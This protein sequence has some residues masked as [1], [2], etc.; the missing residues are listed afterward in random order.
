MKT[1]LKNDRGFALIVA[2]M[3]MVIM[4]SLT[5]AGLLFSGLNLKTTSSHKT[6]TQAFYIADAGLHHV[7]QELDN[8]DGINDFAT[9]YTATETTTLFANTSFGSG[10]YTVTALPIAGSPDRIRVQSTGCL[11]AGCPSGSS[12]AVIEADLIH[13][14]GK[15]PKAVVTNG[16]L[17]I[18]QDPKIMGTRG[19][20]HSNDDMQIKRHPAIEMVN[21]LTASNKA[22][23]EGSIPEGMVIGPSSNPC[24]GSP[25]CSLPSSQQ[26]EENKIN[27]PEKRQAYAASHSSAPQVTIPRINPADY[28]PKV[29]ALAGL[30]PAYIMHDDGTVTTGGS[31]GLDGLCV[32]GTPVPVPTGWRFNEGAWRPGEYAAN[33]IYYSETNIHISTSPGTKE[34][35]WEVTLIA[36]DT[37]MFTN[38]PDMKPY[39]TT[40]NELKNHLL[41][42]GNDLYLHG[43]PRMDYVPGAILVHQQFRISD[44]AKIKGFIIAGDGQPTWPGDPFPP[45]VSSSGIQTNEISGDPWIT[46]NGDFDCLG[47]GCPNP[48]KMLSWREVF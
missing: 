40:S 11:P 24:I 28:A 39:P 3:V 8:S 47:P 15:A 30:E 19:G 46:Y 34:N 33:G 22:R 32:G 9:V 41:V 45:S 20:A 29:A 13:E 38:H 14:V 18:T 31:C 21:G 44:Q 10:S 17:K 12:K 36:R 27:T 37:I 2:I 1:I 23:G 43:S 42:T 4:F 7:W 26:P 6:K 48:V 25:A 16:D 5:G 35:P